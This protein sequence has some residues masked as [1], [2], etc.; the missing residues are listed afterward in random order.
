[1]A[2]IDS[3]IPARIPAEPA[4][5]PAEVIRTGGIR[6]EIRHPARPKIGAETWAIAPNITGKIGGIVAD[7]V[8]IRVSWDPKAGV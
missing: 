5:I 6:A 1:M 8:A 3:T 2:S 4:R 7:V